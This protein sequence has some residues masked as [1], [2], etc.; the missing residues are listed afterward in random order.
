[1][2]PVR[3]N[4]FY[5]A[6][7]VFVPL[8]VY[9]PGVWIAPDLHDVM[10]LAGI[11]AIGFVA[12][13]ALDRSLERADVSVTASFCHLQVVFVA[14]IAWRRQPYLVTPHALAGVMLIAGFALLRWR[15]VMQHAK[16]TR[17]V[18]SQTPAVAGGD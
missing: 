9:V 17:E 2:K 6:V 16:H 12:L 14:F 5:T 13:F 15:E 7:G 3:T 4:L 8:S 1:M 10:V 11:G 18:E